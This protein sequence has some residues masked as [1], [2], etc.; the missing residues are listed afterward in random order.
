MRTMWFAFAIVAYYTAY[1]LVS[2]PHSSLGASLS[3]DTHQRNQI[4]AARG[5]AQSFGLLVALIALFSLERATSIAETAVNIGIGLGGF[6]AA[7]IVLGTWISR[8][9]PSNPVPARSNARAIREVLSNHTARRVLAVLGFQEMALGAL[10]VVLP[11]ASDYILQAPGQTVFYLLAFVENVFPFSHPEL[12]NL[13]SIALCSH[14]SGRLER[15]R[16]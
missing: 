6:A 1:T 12:L 13:D 15:F 10:L 5:A 4:F 11:F 2:V 14:E 7:I 8:E 16:T 9:L 3:R